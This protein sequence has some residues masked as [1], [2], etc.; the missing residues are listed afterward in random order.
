LLSSGICPLQKSTAFQNTKHLLQWGILFYFSKCPI[1]FFIYIFYVNT[2][3]IPLQCVFF[4]GG[5]GEDE[6]Q[7]CIVAKVAND[8]QKERKK[9][10]AKFDYKLYIKNLNFLNIVICF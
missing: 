3:Q 7:F 4:F 10:L 8:A 5:G 6:G 9:D 1:S 2:R